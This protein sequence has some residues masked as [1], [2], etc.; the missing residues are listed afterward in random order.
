[1]ARRL[2]RFVMLGV[3]LRC[4]GPLPPTAPREAAPAS[5]PLRD[6]SGE[7]EPYPRAGTDDRGPASTVSER[8]EARTVD[9]APARLA[10]GRLIDLDVKG[11]DLQDVC[12]LLADVGG[13]NIVVADDARGTVTVRLKRVPWD[14]ALDAIVEA[15]GL[16]TV[17]EG[18]VLLV[19]PQG[20]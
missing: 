18:N 19:K 7:P 20:P 12:R 5:V 1:M 2:P 14:E 15:K 9:P 4:G 16:R 6:T 11:V 13:V 3:V 10:H 8:W 17:R